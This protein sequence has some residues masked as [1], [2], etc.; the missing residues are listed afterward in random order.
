[1]INEVFSE[2]SSSLERAKE[3]LKRELMKV[4]TGRANLGLLDGIRVEFYGTLTPLNQ[5]G[6]L[7]V[8]EP[9]LITIQPW[10]KSIISSIERAISASDL[11]LNPSNDGTLI[12]IPIPALTG[13]RR[14]ELVK[15]VK[16]IGEESKISVRNERRGAND[17]VKQLEKEG[18]VSQD[19]MHRGLTKIQQI[20]DDAIKLVDS[21][22][23]DKETEILE[24]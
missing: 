17:L 1:M 18:E 16:R 4:R 19:E 21:I 14:R 20:T 3:A 9:R 2:L 13:E 23:S 15:L 8:P 11:G 7:K 10:D 5:V 22:L 12:R 24:F 6:T